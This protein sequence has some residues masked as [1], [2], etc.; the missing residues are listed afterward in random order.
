MGSIVID[1][2]FV[3]IKDIKTLVTFYVLDK[4]PSFV[5]R[6]TLPTK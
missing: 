2:H 1:L 5:S 4:R 6:A 3:T